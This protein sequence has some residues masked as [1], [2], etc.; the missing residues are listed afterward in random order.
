MYLGGGYGRRTWVTEGG[1]ADAQEE[2][3]GT[4]R[5]M[6]RCT[7]QQPQPTHIQNGRGKKWEGILIE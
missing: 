6:R 5:D 7:A 4:Q 1:G 2:T 3:A